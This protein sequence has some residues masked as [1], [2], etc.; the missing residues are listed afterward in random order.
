MNRCRRSSFD[1]LAPTADA[2]WLVTRNEIREAI[3]VTPLERKANL[4]TILSAARETRVADGWKAD[5]IGRSCA[6]FFCAKDGARL[7]VGIERRDPA[8]PTLGHGGRPV[9]TPRR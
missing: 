8:N 5:P 2:T 4:R 6:F 7:M 1:P 3:E 9:R